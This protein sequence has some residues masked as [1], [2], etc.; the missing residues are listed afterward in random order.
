M[1]FLISY[2]LHLRGCTTLGV[3]S[4]D[5]HSQYPQGLHMQNLLTHGQLS[6]SPRGQGSTQYAFLLLRFRYLGR[7]F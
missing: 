3:P 6:I 2:V 4:W 7:N 5:R 1:N